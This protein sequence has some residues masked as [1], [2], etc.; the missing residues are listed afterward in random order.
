MAYSKSE[1]QRT[2]RNSKSDYAAGVTVFLR[3]KG[4]G[5][6]KDKGKGKPE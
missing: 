3:N 1:F 6:G 4:K 2:E 5:K